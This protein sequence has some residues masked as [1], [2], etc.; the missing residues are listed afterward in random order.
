MK[1]AE[2]RELIS[3]ADALTFISESELLWHLVEGIGK[4][5]KDFD[6][7]SLLDIVGVYIHKILVE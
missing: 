1:H 4:S 2:Y 5:P 3:L 7:P 6:I